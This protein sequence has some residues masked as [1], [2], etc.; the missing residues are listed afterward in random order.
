MFKHL[1]ALLEQNKWVIL[2]C[3]KM[4]PASDVISLRKISND[5][6]AR[7]ISLTS[8]VQF[9]DTVLSLA[10]VSRLTRGHEPPLAPSATASVL[11]VGEHI[12]R[13]KRKDR[14]KMLE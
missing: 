13:S 14:K 9:N 2:G 3:L 8:E 12:S 10:S 5:W 7:P 1:V 6:Q 4:N 11:E